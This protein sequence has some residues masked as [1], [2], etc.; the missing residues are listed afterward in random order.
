MVP[1]QI[2]FRCTMTGTPKWLRDLNV[3]QDTIKLLEENTGKTFSDTNH[4]NVFLGQFSKAIEIKTGV[5]IVVQQK[6]IQLGTMKL[7]VQ[8]LALLSGLRI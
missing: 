1:S 2:N 5:P 3:R 6:R 4:T 7:Q 8:S